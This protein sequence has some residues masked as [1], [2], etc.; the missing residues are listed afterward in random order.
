MS[1]G[2]ILVKQLPSAIGADYIKYTLNVNDDFYSY[3][4]KQIS[5]LCFKKIRPVNHG[6][7]ENI[8]NA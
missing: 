3:C 1:E 4:T 5:W 8:L 7:M 6:L 2:S